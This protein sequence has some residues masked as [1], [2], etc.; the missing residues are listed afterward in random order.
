MCSYSKVERSALKKPYAIYEILQRSWPRH[1]LAQ[2]AQPS[3]LAIGMVW[4]QRASLRL[5]PWALAK[6]GSEEACVTY[7]HRVYPHAYLYIYI[8]YVW[9]FNCIYFF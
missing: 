5:R 2:M 1:N 9:M 4:L 3:V 6:R 8:V 7:T